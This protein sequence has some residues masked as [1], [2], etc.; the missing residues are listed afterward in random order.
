MKKLALVVL[1]GFAFA[2]AHAQLAFGIKGGANISNINGSGVSGTNSLVGFNAG[3]YLHLPLAHHLSLQPEVMYSGQ[4]FKVSSGGLTTDEHENYINVPVLLK[5]THVT[6]LFIETGP[7][8]GFLATAKAVTNGTDFNNKSSF[9]SAD[10][11]WVLGVG[12]KVPATPVSIDARYNFGVS[13]ILTN[14]GSS[15]ESSNSVHNGSFQIGIMV[16]LF[17]AP[18]R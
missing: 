14:N 3:V 6:G 2:T 12:L 4:G 15:G 18:G 7:Q 1:A 8:I 13:N 10:F 9:N 11:S 5:Y 16:R 17:S